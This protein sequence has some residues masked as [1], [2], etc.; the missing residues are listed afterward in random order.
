[1][2]YVFFGQSYGNMHTYVRTCKGLD[3]G[4]A[5]QL[6]YQ[7]VSTVAHCHS[8]DVV[9]RD[10]KLR[11][12]VFKNQERTHLTLSNFE[13][14]YIIEKGD[15]CVYGRHDCHFYISPEGLQTEV[16]HSG[17]AAD[18]WSLGVMLY[19][20]LV[21]H[22]PFRD[23]ESNILFCKIQR[24]DFILPE[25][26]SPKAKCLIQNIFRVDPSERLTA[27]EILDHPWLSFHDSQKVWRT[28][29]Y[30]DDDQIVPQ[31]CC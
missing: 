13:D 1:M 3:E 14:A 31:F 28:I 18:V 29:S 30:Q 10:L 5:S 26:L 22:Y 24:C 21:G 25:F 2:V 9:L 7:M 17:K 8:N 23:L 20:I 12:F 11:K 6:F 15:D 27:P 4:E 19:T 16:K